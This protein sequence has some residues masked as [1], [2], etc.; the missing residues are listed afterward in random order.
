MAG[1]GASIRPRWPPLGGQAGVRVEVALLD[2][3]GA[4]GLRRWQVINAA[5]VLHGHWLH[6]QA[7]GDLVEGHNL[8]HQWRPRSPSGSHPNTTCGHRKQQD[9]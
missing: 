5:L 8:L 6:L 4:T 2:A 7:T 9:S 1:R 3:L